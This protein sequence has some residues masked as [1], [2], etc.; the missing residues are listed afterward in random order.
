MSVERSVLVRLSG[1]PSALALCGDIEAARRRARKALPGDRADVVR[2][3]SLSTQLEREGID[4]IRSGADRVEVPATN[5]LGLSFLGTEDLDELPEEAAAAARG[6]LNGGDLAVE[7]RNPF[8]LGPT[9]WEG[10]TRLD[11]PPVAERWTAPGNEQGR[12]AVAVRFQGQLER[13]A[14]GRT[15]AVI[16]PSGVSNSVLT[17]GLR[18]Y[19]AA[20]ES[21]ERIDAPVAY[22]DGSTARPFPLRALML[23]TDPP[24]ARVLRFALLS[25]R[26]TEMDVE[27]DGAWLRNTEI[28]RLRPA[29]ETDELVYVQSRRQLAKLAEGEP[30]TIFMYQTGLETAVMGFYRA[31][32]EHLIERPGSVAVVPMYF[33]RQ[34]KAIRSVAGAAQESTFARGTPWA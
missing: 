4:A 20:A 18:S 15:G 6:W 32:T 14:G 11:A 27:V 10:S 19:V 31:L 13:V 28:S 34:R 26:H 2:F 3:E 5:R 21:A 12:R 23:A 7:V 9:R 29:G 8:G 1:S 30:A 17:E 22:R 24:E 33:R 25:I 16:A